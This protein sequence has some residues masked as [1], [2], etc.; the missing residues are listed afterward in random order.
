[1]KNLIHNNKK[2]NKIS[3]KKISTKIAKK[4]IFKGMMI[5]IA[6][7]SIIF[8]IDNILDERFDSMEIF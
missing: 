5:K 6:G 2:K 1:M 3:V 4:V 8:S 7:R